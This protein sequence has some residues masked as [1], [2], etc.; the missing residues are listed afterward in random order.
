MITDPRRPTPRGRRIAF[1]V[2][3][4]VGIGLAVV[5][6]GELMALAVLGWLDAAALDDLYPGASIHR[7]HV[8]AQ[9]AIAWSIAIGI[10]IQPWRSSRTFAAAIAAL[11]ALAAYTG[12]AA[13]GGVFDPMAVIG[14]AALGVIVWTHPARDAAQRLPL[15]PRML[16][17]GGPLIIGGAILVV[18]QLI[19]QL[20]ASA[21]EP[22]AAIGHYAF[23]AAMA[24]GLV[25]A[26]LIGATSLPGRSLP[27]WTAVGGT[28]YYGVASIVFPTQASSLGTGGG[29]VAV[30]A[31]A[32][33]AIGIITSAKR[34]LDSTQP[35]P[36]PQPIG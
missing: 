35:E 36:R 15:H 23:T 13:I 12:A 34:A 6:L 5:G 32:G 9:A 19:A 16:A 7:M 30:V 31:A 26:A 10:L 3:V 27:A 25:A 29:I 4:V 24:V 33:Y 28:L 22:H 2:A 8:L 17:L 1:Y 11:V 21:T 18:Q 20:S 14:V